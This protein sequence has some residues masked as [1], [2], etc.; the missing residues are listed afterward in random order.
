MLGGWIKITLGLGVMVSLPTFAQDFHKNPDTYKQMF[1]AFADGGAYSLY[2]YS[3]NQDTVDL[4]S[5][6]YVHKLAS[7]SYKR[8]VRFNL[9]PLCLIRSPEFPTLYVHNINLYLSPSGIEVLEYDPLLSS[10]EHDEDLPQ[11]ECN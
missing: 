8:S 5:I 11:I 3:L 6:S 1:F 7:E 4:L 10:I 9:K 2:G